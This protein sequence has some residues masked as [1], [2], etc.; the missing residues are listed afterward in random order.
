MIYEEKIEIAIIQSKAVGLPRKV[1][2]GK[3]DTFR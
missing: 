3:S 1:F 2:K